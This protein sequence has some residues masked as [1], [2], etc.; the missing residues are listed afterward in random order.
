MA[1]SVSDT[2]FY[3]LVRGKL[4][5][6]NEVLVH[7]AVGAEGAH[8]GMLAWDAPRTARRSKSEISIPHRFKLR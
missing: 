4:K 7:R 5:N 8:R 3:I 1:T 6:R 2:P